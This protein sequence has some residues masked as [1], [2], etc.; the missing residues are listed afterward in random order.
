VLRP[1]IMRIWTP[2]LLQRSEEVR[3]Q[4]GIVAL[5]VDIVS[6]VC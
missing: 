2:V 5:E 6:A 4:T 3:W 1:L